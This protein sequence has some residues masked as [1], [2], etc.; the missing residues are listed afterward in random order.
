MTAPFANAQSMAY[1]V[2]LALMV[3]MNMTGTMIAP[4]SRAAGTML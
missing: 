2:Y 1:H 3:T 4:S